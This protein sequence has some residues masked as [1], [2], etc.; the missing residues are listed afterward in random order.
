MHTGSCQ[1][2][3]TELFLIFNTDKEY[4]FLHSLRSLIFHVSA[5]T[6]WQ[7]PPGKAVTYRFYSWGLWMKAGNTL[8]P[9]KSLAPRPSKR[10]KRRHAF[11]IPSL[12]HNFPNVFPLD[13][14]TGAIFGEIPEQLWDTP[15]I[16]KRMTVTD[17]YST[18]LGIAWQRQ[19][20]PAGIRE[21]G[22]ER[23][24]DEPK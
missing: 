24:R 11:R 14:S 21:E 7:G 2:V 16:T 5:S 13:H 6:V 15:S 4:I 23:Q 20:M 10:S 17:W 9:V 18:A 3:K 19:Q 12:T 22:M 1:K 8:Q